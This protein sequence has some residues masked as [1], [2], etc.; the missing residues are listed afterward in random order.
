MSAMPEIPAEI[1]RWRRIA[2]PASIILNLFLMAVIGGHIWR[3]HSRN[4]TVGM[5]IARAISRAE[6]V[7]PP[8]D[9]AAFGAVMRRDAAHYALTAQR[10]RDAREELNRQLVAEPFDPEAT[11][12]ALQ[13]LETAWAHFLNDFSGTL[14]EGLSQVSPEG[15]RKL[16]ETPPFGSHTKPAD[17]R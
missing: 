9:A 17:P 15:R 11:R 16:L 5:P 13:G 8:Q 12:R 14:I 3:A 10:L 2:L 4:D 6:D 1:P 7:L